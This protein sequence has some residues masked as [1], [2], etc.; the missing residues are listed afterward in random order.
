MN[1]K[2][3]IN[4]LLLVIVVGG[5]LWLGQ[6][7]QANKNV[8]D[9]LNTNASLGPLISVESEFDFGMISMARGRVNHSFTI[10]NDSSSPITINKIYTSCMCTSATIIDGLGQRIGPF[11]MPG[12]G[13][14]SRANA[15]IAPQEFMT[16]EAVFDPAA[17]GPSGVGLAQRSIYLETIDNNSDMVS[18]LELSF[19][20]TVTQ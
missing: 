14:A 9:N 2:T 11:G 10:K 1:K 18:K 6:I 8:A 3:I 4:G 20:A 15:E 19:T 17:H 13:G 7:N 12:H 5:L 16:I